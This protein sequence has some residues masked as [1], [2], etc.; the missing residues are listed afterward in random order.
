[1]DVILDST[2]YAKKMSW[3]SLNLPEELEVDAPPA[4]A[5]GAAH[6]MSFPVLTEEFHVKRLFNHGQERC[7]SNIEELEEVGSLMSEG[8]PDLRP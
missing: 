2:R 3:T 7:L 8:S 6:S 5:C 1:M 4:P